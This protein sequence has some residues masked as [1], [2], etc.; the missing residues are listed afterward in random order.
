MGADKSFNEASGCSQQAASLQEAAVHFKHRPPAPDLIARAP[1]AALVLCPTPLLQTQIEQGLGRHMAQGLNLEQAV[2]SSARTVAID[3]A[4]IGPVMR[5]RQFNALIEQLGR[6]SLRAHATDYLPESQPL[7]SAKGGL[8]RWQEAV[9]AG[10]GLAI[11]AGLFLK[12]VATLY[13]LG[14][15]LGLIFFGI[16]FLR[17]ACLVLHFRHKQ[18][19]PIKA[20]L[21]VLPTQELPIYSI[22]VPLFREPEV[23]AILIDGLKRLNY[24]AHRLDIK[25]ILEEQDFETINTLSTLE[26]P[27]QFE[28]LTVPS[29]QPQT[30]PR[31]LNYALPFVIG[32]YVV[33]YDAEDIPDPDQLKKAL[34][35]FQIDGDDLACVQAQL[36]YYNRSENWLTRQFTIEYAML[37]DII[38]PGY[39]KMGLPI[40]LGGTSTHFRTNLLRQ[41]GGWDAYNVTEDAD[42]GMRLARAGYRCKILQ[43]TTYEEANCQ[44]INWLR[45]RSRWCKGWLQTWLIHMREPRQLY[46]DLGFKKFL[47]FQAVAGGVVFSALAYPLFLIFLAAGVV[48]LP[49]M[50]GEAPAGP[51]QTTMMGLHGLNIL[52]GYGVA[53]ALGLAAVA[54][55]GWRWLMP[56]CLGLPVYW[57]LIAAGSYYG[58]IQL[59]TRP[60]FWEKTQHGITR[61]QF[62]ITNRNF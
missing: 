61:M 15:V 5:R 18:P 14:L 4:L 6:Y 29:G 17:G 57:L 1:S 53:I 30:K 38:L 52:A 33:I 54:S 51:L 35:L 10:L 59:F 48:S 43:S 28:I 31:A 47:G 37:F 8:A 60:F 12:P 55:R 34:A 22:L 2:L 25:L 45:Q 39:E 20:E 24:P 42:L 44:T 46:R 21:A 40:P 36:N 16:N 9:L 3:D 19:A 58:L 49:F 23:V 56:A 26:L 7:L 32:D 13:V 50:G 41:I 27:A 62:R 11:P